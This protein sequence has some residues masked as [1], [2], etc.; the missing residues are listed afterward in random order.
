LA[1]AGLFCQVNVPAMATFHTYILYSETA[2]RYYIGQTE[3]LEDRLRRHN[4]GYE[5]AT[6]PYAPWKL[7]LAI[8]KPSRSEAVILESK[9]KNLNKT[10]VK[11]FIEKYKEKG[12][13]SP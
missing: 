7:E 9:L 5:K 3:D 10:R 6:A 11:A 4:S 2:N 1:R 13:S 12:D 8:P